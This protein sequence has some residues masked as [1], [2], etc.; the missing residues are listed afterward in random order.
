[1]NRYWK[2]VPIIALALAGC[3]TAHPAV[4]PEAVVDRATKQ[5]DQA[6]VLERRVSVVAENA[7]SGPF[8]YEITDRTKV[9]SFEGLRRRE[10]AAPLPEGAKLVSFEGRTM[11]PDGSEVPA[12]AAAARVEE[13]KILFELPQPAVGAVLEYRFKV[14]SPTSL[15]LFYWQ[16]QRE[17]PVV[18]AGLTISWPKTA[19]LGY[20]I[21]NHPSGQPTEPDVGTTSGPNKKKLTR[22][23]WS[24]FDLAARPQEKDRFAIVIGPK[25]FLTE[26]NRSSGVGWE[27]GFEGLDNYLPR[28]SINLDVPP[29]GQPP[30][31]SGTGRP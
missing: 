31:N 15:A 16:F 24:F 22:V 5:K 19:K 21:V 8:S 7:I 6:I 12:D 10:V 23:S 25:E 26:A 30:A 4:N 2:W 1:M 29:T 13:G 9:L 28:T 18:S 27:A 14:H 17:I 3:T 20:Q 11:Q